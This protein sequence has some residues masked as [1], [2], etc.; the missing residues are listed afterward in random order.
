MPIQTTYDAVPYPNNPCPFSHIERLATV[1][2]LLGMSPAPIR[3]AR[4]LELGCS[5]GGNLIPMADQF[6]ESRFV[7]IELAETQVRSACECIDSLGLTNI[8]IRNANILELGDDLGDF[9]YIIAHGVYSWVTR[10]VRDKVLSICRNQLRPHG[11]AFLSYNTLPGWKMRGM[12]R[13][14]MNFHIAAIPDPEDRLVQARRLLEFLAESV[15]PETPYGSV[16]K[17]ELEVVNSHSDGYLYHDHLE[18]INEPFYF[19]QF[20]QHADQFGLQYLGEA[21]LASMYGDQLPKDVSQ[22]LEQMG[23]DIIR[24]EQYFDFVCNR[25]IRQSLL[26]HREIQVQRAMRTFDLESLYVSAPLQFSNTNLENVGQESIVF[27]HARLNVNVTVTHPLLL[28]MLRRLAE[29]WPKRWLYSELFQ[30]S[31]SELRRTDPNVSWNTAELRERCATTFFRFYTSDLVE[32]GTTAG[33]FTIDIEHRPL[34]SRLARFQLARGATHV[35]TLNHQ[36]RPLSRLE[37]YLLP[38]L[39][40]QNDRESLRAQVR[41]GIEDDQEMEAN[42]MMTQS[43]QRGLEVEIDAALRSLARAP[44]LVDTP[45]P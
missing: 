8:E 28:R 32:L 3:A 38:L 39:N 25:M 45:H 17:S 31:L 4:V 34:A 16:L 40:G 1:A 43:L 7:G 42:P 27:R 13:E 11:V 15:P 36:A 44:L 24:R 26:C 23:S 22:K 41:N 9:D 6:P 19:Y 18:E 20:A 14:M 30:D 21:S 2:T 10:E 5:R 37:S 29:Q 12:I 35:T 33:G